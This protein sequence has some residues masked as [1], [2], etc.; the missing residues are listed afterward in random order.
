MDIY[1]IIRNRS[2]PCLDM[3][4]Y[5]Q[6]LCSELGYYTD[7]S[8]AEAKVEALNAH[9]LACERENHE[10]G[11]EPSVDEENYYSYVPLDLMS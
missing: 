10:E 5:E 6:C 4:D 11:W 9:Y 8:L 3:V 7:V 2:I 1:V